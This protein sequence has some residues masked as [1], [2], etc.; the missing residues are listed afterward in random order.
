MRKEFKVR[1]LVRGTIGTHRALPAAVRT[2]LRDHRACRNGGS[3]S[4]ARVYVSVDGSPEYQ[5]PVDV[6]VDGT[7][8]IGTW[9]DRVPEYVIEA[10][11]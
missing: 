5:V 11:D 6:D 2:M 4:D 1:G 9:S 8:V 3:Y 10:V 7:W